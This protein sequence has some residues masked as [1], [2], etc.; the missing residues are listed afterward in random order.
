M[1]TPEDEGA[2]HS[3]LIRLLPPIAAQGEPEFPAVLSS[4]DPASFIT[5]TCRARTLGGLMHMTEI[6]PKTR[7]E[8]QRGQVIHTQPW[9]EI[10]EHYHNAA[11]FAPMRRL[12]EAI[13]SS[14][15]GTELYGANST[16]DLLLSDC[17][18]FRFGDST[19]CIAY[20]PSEHVFE[21]RHHCF[22]GHDDKKTCPECEA[23]QTLRLFLELKYG[24]PFERVTA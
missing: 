5:T 17:Q 21:F 1:K 3:G 19:L 9:P 16:F 7:L 22:S 8:G 12:V 15:A 10:I 4:A 23:F 20:R 13:A 11:S 2:N 24:V 18:D 6:T 14:P